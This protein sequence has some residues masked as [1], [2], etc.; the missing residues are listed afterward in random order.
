MSAP[1]SNF[2]R[3]L[4]ALE[5]LAVQESIQLAGDNYAA[6]RLTQERS[7][8]LVA[9][10]ARLNRTPLT[11][12]L[13]ARVEA[14]LVRR[15]KHEEQLAAVIATVRTALLKSQANRRRIGQIAPVYG[16]HARIRLPR[17]PSLAHAVA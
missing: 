13:Q 9:E 3:L 2:V 16:H 5:D 17:A 15:A 12:D 1:E 14:L 11:A 7:A 6:V 4:G 10:L 8:P